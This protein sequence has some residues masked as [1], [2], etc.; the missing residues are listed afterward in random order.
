MAKVAHNTPATD[1]VF[2]TAKEKA[3]KLVEVLVDVYAQI[4][5]INKYCEGCEKITR[6]AIEELAKNENNAYV[7]NA[8]EKSYAKACKK[9]GGKAVENLKAEVKADGF[10]F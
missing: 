2:K 8:Y 6:E 3:V 10:D 5:A 7:I 4:D 1:P 9:I